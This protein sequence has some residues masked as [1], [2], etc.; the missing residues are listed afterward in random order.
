MGD[1]ELLV[2]HIL[3]SCWLS[4]DRDSN[5]HVSHLLGSRNLH[6]LTDRSQLESLTT[7]TFARGQWRNLAFA[8]IGV[9]QPIGYSVG[10]VLGGVFTD[11]IGWPGAS[12]SAP[13]STLSYRYV[14]YGSC[15]PSVG[16]REN[17][18]NAG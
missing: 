5:Y 12:T 9:G 11:T 8:S 17:H 16:P 4:Q 6:V 18:G 1:G 7:N 14:P 10:L 2:C 3:L 13:S 15:L